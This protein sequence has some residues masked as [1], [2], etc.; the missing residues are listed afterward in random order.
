M[1]AASPALDPR[2]YLAHW[3][4]DELPFELAPNTRY[5]FDTDHH[6]EGLARILFGLSEIGGAVLVTGEVGAGKTLLAKIVARILGGGGFEVGLIANPPATAAGA[7]GAL[8]E[9]LGIER[10]GGGTG[11]IAA[12]LRA[13]A[14]DAA[15]SGRRVVAIVDEA[16]RLDRKA[17]DELRLL[18]NPEEGSSVSL[19][20]LGQPELAGHVR[21][22]PALDQRV[23]VRYR[24]GAMTPEETAAYVDRRLRIAGAEG[25]VFSARA[26][27]QVHEATGGVPRLVNMLCA[28]AL[29]VAYSRG[30]RSIS[31][32]TVRDLVDDRRTA[33]DGA[34]Q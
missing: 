9:S 10:S 26:L 31:E 25:Q 28:N 6:R 21:R 4:L 8:A 11:K 33:D 22:L 2:A 20:L 27:R 24:M 17:L 1:H 12:R 30:E 3:A 7:L 19:V 18:T 13:R 23:V 34:T 32:D 14:A 15:N 16:Q 5:R 29:F